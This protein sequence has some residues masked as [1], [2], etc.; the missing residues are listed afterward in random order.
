LDVEGDDNV[1][2][3]DVIPAGSDWETQSASECHSATGRYF[4]QPV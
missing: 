2:C 1:V 3:V 4:F